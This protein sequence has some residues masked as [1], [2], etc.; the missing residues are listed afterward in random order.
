[1]MVRVVLKTPVEIS[2]R[3]CHGLV[4]ILDGGLDHPA[5]VVIERLTSVETSVTDAR[6]PADTA[7][8]VVVPWSNILAAFAWDEPEETDPGPET[9]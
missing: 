8:T 3:L 9:P 2:Q 4:G 1:M 7:A 6:L 5:T